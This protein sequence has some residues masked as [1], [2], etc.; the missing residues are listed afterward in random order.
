[1]SIF[2]V[3]EN[4]HECVM[5]LSDQHLVLQLKK[6]ADVLVCALNQRGINGPL[7]KGDLP[8]DAVVYVD[9]AM[10]D[11]DHFLWLTYY[12]MALAEEINHRTRTIPPTAATVYA[13]GNIAHAMAERDF[14]FPEEWPW[15][16]NSQ[17]YWHCDVFFAY[18]RLLKTRYEE[19][20]ARGD[21]PTW[22]RTHPPEWL[23]DTCVLPGGGR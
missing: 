3:D 17:E 22:T 8:L 6:T 16:E 19:D 18:Q 12:G 4:P 11:W 15:P 2:I 20:C 13:A 9:W 5:P 21:I 10:V 1:M 7:L 23:T 14:S